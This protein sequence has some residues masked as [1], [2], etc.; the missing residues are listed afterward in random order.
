M[1][2]YLIAALA[3][4]LSIAVAAVAVGQDT[5]ATMT[6]N[7]SPAKAGTKKKPRTARVKV[8]I[9]NNV[10]DTTASK[11]EIFFPKNAK[12]STKGLK[13]C[14]QAT[15]NAKGKSSCPAKS[16]AG[17]GVS[18]AVVG[19]QHAPLQFN[20]TNF[21]GGKNLVL[22]YI[23]QKGGTVRKA[24]P[25]KIGPARDAKYGQKI[26]ITIPEDLQQPATG[27]YSALTDITASLYNK[28]G[29]HSLIKVNGC[30][31]SKKHRFGARLTFVPN[32]N[33]PSQS[34]AQTNTTAPCS[35]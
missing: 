17:V 15:L 2:K 9:K 29:K 8:F 3:A 6:A 35:K 10:P 23:E 5:D 34:T 18:N 33:P 19:P 21:V 7:V 24:L 28:N 26:T 27:V 25:G 13:F 20:V 30:P 16:K 31:A 12:L 14:K 32:P 4:V 11:I 22:F 1:R